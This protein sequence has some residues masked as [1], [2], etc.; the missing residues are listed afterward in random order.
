MIYEL[1]AYNTDCRFPSDIR[2]RDYTSSRRKPRSLSKS[3]KYN[4]LI[5][6]TA[7]CLYQ[8]NIEDAESL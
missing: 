4:F 8:E 1:L 3:L 5:A 2:Y 7:L 6:D